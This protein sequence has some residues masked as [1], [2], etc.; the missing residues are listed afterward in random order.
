MLQPMPEIEHNAPRFM[1]RVYWRRD[2]PGEQWV[3]NDIVNWEETK[4]IVPDQPTFQQ[5]RIKVVAINEKGEA[6]VAPKEVT[7]YSG[8][9]GESEGIY[10]DNFV[11]NVGY[12]YHLYTTRIKC[13]I[14]L[15]SLHVSAILGHHQRT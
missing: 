14:T 6:N 2:I 9:D 1:Y 4:L 11:V 5:Y 3:S 12:I 13:N 7:G 10:R 8:E 15:I